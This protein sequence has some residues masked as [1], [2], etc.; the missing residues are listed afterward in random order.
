M[1]VC[2][3]THAPSLSK[4]VSSTS[5]APRPTA[6]TAHCTASSPLFTPPDLTCVRSEGEGEGEGE[7]Q[8]EGEGEG[9]GEGGPEASRLKSES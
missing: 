7:G 9:E 3:S 8:G 5:P 6:F 4:D 1:W 2:W